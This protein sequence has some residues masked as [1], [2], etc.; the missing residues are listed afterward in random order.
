MVIFVS[1]IFPVRNDRRGLKSLLESLRCQT[2]PADSFEVI[3]VQ[4]CT[5]DNYQKLI[6][7][8]TNVCLLREDSRPNAYTARNAGVALALSRGEGRGEILAFTDADCLPDPRWLEEGIKCLEWDKVDIVAGAI[9]FNLPD[10]PTAAQQL[11]TVLFLQQERNV[12][13][14]QLAS[15]ANLFV[16][17]AVFDR[18]GLFPDDCE[19]GGDTLVSRRAVLAGFK[20]VY[21]PEAIVMH[22][23]TRTTIPLLQKA[24][25]IGRGIAYR[26]TL[27]GKAAEAH[28]DHPLRELLKP[29]KLRARLRQKSLR[30]SP[31]RFGMMVVL[32]YLV[33]ATGVAGY[34]Q[35]R[36]RSMFR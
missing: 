20:L 16:K 1:I 28:G 26:R 24:F 10:K 17:R 3:I 15:T 18:L 13:Q 31:L 2:Y 22:D 29:S 14:R 12:R 4:N 19:S 36:I 9:R 7:E 21:C 32:V 27:R 25:R 8:Y 6:S 5:N 33:A 11:D 23:Q 35:W 30:I 34:A